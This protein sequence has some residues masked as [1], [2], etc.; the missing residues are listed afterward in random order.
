M[1]KQ[2][3]KG[4]VDKEKITVLMATPLNAPLN[5]AVKVHR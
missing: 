5:L 1:S 4:R 2:F 3:F